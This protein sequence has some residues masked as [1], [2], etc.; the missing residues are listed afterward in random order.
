[1][2]LISQPRLVGPDLGTNCLQSISAGNELKESLQETNHD[3][4]EYL[5]KEISK[6]ST[7]AHLT[8][9]LIVDWKCN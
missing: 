2:F 9:A 4:C 5:G 6:G 7:F 8:R 3:S 1:M